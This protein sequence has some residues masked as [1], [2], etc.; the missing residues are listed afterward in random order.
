MVLCLIHDYRAV[1]LV[2]RQDHNVLPLFFK[3]SRAFQ[4]DQGRLDEGGLVSTS[5]PVRPCLPH[6]Q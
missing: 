6:L 3:S 4:K 5:D 2:S 1:A